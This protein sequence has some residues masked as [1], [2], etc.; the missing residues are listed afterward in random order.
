MRGQFSSCWCQVFSTLSSFHPRSCILW[1]LPSLLQR[2]VFS[3]VEIYE[4]NDLNKRQMREEASGFLCRI[5]SQAGHRSKVT[6]YVTGS[7]DTRNP[8]LNHF[9]PHTTTHHSKLSLSCAVSFSWYSFLLYC[10]DLQK[11]NSNSMLISFIPCYSWAQ[12]CRGNCLPIQ[13]WQIGSGGIK[14]CGN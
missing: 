8:F 9:P 1:C 4:W 3:S 11:D 10:F 13:G 2:S 6:L 14:Q 5:S 7:T 12:S